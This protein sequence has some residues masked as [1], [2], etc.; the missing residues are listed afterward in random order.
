VPVVAVLVGLQASGK[1][2]FCQRMLGPGFVVVSK[3]HFRHA[4]HPQ[5]RQ[6]HLVEEALSTGRDVVVDNT[7]P[8]PQEWAPLIDAARAHGARV[9][10]YWFPPDLAGSLQRNAA[11]PDGARIPEPGLRAT[12][13]RLLHPRVRDGFDEVFAVEFDGSGGFIVRPAGE[14]NDDQEP[15]GGERN[16]PTEREAP[17]S[18]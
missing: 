1:T 2:T 18:P 17:G 5:R 10:A 8:S 4:R 3:A 12:R 14:E 9:I 6:M 13:A 7:N 11:R 16:G 15:A